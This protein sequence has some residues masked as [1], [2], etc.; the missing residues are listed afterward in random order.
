MVGRNPQTLTTSMF[1]VAL[2]SEQGGLVGHFPVA[3]TA[4]LTQSLIISL[5]SMT[6]ALALHATLKQYLIMKCVV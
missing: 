4:L 2:A 1:A 3:I 6:P 5:W